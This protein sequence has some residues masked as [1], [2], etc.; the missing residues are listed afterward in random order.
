VLQEQDHIIAASVDASGKRLATVS[1]IGNIATVRS[2]NLAAGFL[3]FETV[4]DIFTLD[5]S[6]IF[7]LGSENIV[8]LTDWTVASYNAKGETLWTHAV[9]SRDTNLQSI[10]HDVGANSVSIVGYTKKM[11]FPYF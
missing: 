3:V 9:A 7:L 2:W 1:V 10:H 11:V 5:A 6:I 8:L 4:T